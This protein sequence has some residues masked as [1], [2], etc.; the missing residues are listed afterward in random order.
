MICIIRESR[1]DDEKGEETEHRK[2][3]GHRYQQGNAGS[4][5]LVEEVENAGSRMEK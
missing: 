2:K 3:W 5:R 4:G 1:K